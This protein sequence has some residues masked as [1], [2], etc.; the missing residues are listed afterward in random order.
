MLYV[1]T[2]VR[3]SD[4]KTREKIKFEY[5]LYIIYCTTNITFVLAISVTNF[6]VKYI[7]RNCFNTSIF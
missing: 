4:D 6:V 2:A 3:K 7:N 1:L 5:A